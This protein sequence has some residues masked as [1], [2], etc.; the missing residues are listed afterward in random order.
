MFLSDAVHDYLLYL[1]HEQNA[2]PQTVRCYRNAL[3]RFADW[4]RE[5]GHPAAT[6]ADI[7]PPLA[8]RYL[9]HLNETGLRPRSRLRLWT[10]IRSLFRMLVD[11][12]VVEDSP[13]EK[14]A[15][16]KK[17]PPQRLLVSDEEL[18]QVLEAAGR[19]RTAWRA[20]R[21]Q[22]VLAVLIYTGI[23]RTESLDL[24][25]QDV[26]LSRRTL[27]VAHGKGD[28]ARTVPLCREVKEYLARW[29]ELRPPA[30]CDWL[31]VYGRTRRLSSNGLAQLLEQAKLVAGLGNAPNIKPHSIRHRAATRLL[32]NGA[33]LRSVQAWLG[34][35]H[36]STTA[37]YL[38]CDEKRLQ[39]IAHY[40]SFQPSPPEPE[41]E[42]A[43]RPGPSV[44]QSQP[45]RGRL[46]HGGTQ[47][48]RF[49]SR[50]ERSQDRG[51]TR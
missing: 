10:P 51:G 7:T 44:S 22:A 42:P 49:V 34:H 5:N 8:R 28:K 14:I 50:Y 4:L 38:H 32:Q 15:L 9:Y 30:E 20:A 43:P 36:L 2:S 37:V 11:L 6:L 18:L 23:R 25:V 27:Y 13:V 35:S 16:P 26:D 21:D 29:L 12:Q 17:D 19:Q 39:S 45:E 47:G 3:G 40:A 46:P 1:Q 41:P 33:D 24:R 31:F 48:R